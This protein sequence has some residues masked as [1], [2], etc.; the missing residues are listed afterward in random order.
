MDVATLTANSVQ[1]RGGRPR[2]A[3]FAALHAAVLAPL[4]VWAIAVPAVGLRLQIRFGH[5]AAQQVGP[6]DIVTASLFGALLG[7]GCLALLERR[8][9]RARTLW[10]AAAIVALLASLALPLSTGTTTSTGLILALMHLTV[11]AALIPVLYRTSPWQP[12][13]VSTPADQPAC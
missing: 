2:L 11:G 8:T 13:A 3:R 10:T 5:A 12:A 6:R 4:A 1:I 7:W 9:H